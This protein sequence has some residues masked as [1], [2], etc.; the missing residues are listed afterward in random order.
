MDKRLSATIVPAAVA[1]VVG[2]VLLLTGPRGDGSQDARIA[3]V[4]GELD[5]R[6]RETSAGVQARA[7]TLS[8]LPRLGWAVSTD[9]DTV[10]DL[11]ADELA[12]RPLPGESIEI[13][14]IQL[15]GGQALT[16][17]RA[18]PGDTLKLPVA[19][20][21]QRLL[22]DGDR[23]YIAAI[24]AITAQ[25]RADEIRGS[26]VVAQR[27]DLRAVNLRLETVR[28][29]VKI[30]TAEGTIVL[31]SGAVPNSARA[32]TAT[33]GSPAAQ[34]AKVTVLTPASGGSGGGR[35][36]AATIV[37]VL[38]LALSGISWMR[39]RRT[40]YADDEIPRPSAKPT[41]PASLVR[42]PRPTP[43][44]PS[45]S[46]VA[47]PP[48]PRLPSSPASPRVPSSPPFARSPSAPPL[49]ATASPPAS[50]SALP[51]PSPSRSASAGPPPPPP[52]APASH[53]SVAA[54]PTPPSLHTLPFPPSPAAAAPPR[55]TVDRRPTPIDPARVSKGGLPLPSGSRP[56]SDR[57]PTPHVSDSG[58][59]SAV[60]DR[61]ATPLVPLPTLEASGKHALP[62][63]EIT[64]TDAPQAAK[65]L[66][67]PDSTAAP[68]AVIVDELSTTLTS[69]NADLARITDRDRSSL[70]TKGASTTPEY[71]ALF[72]EFV[73]LR[74]TCGE[75]T[76]GL[77]AEKF[78]MVLGQ[79]RAEL[80]SRHAY[81]DVRFWVGFNDGKA[82]IR[83]RGIR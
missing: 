59:A 14:Q 35:P 45:P 75:P 68:V 76:E 48:P 74:R 77:D 52:T 4:V 23:L 7:V 42:D 53:G 43:A 41:E 55:S 81:K 69:L 22:I 36:I 27:L 72:R 16:L 32:A 44:L 28:T 39:G 15:Q 38:G 12:F 57:R 47:N 54:S 46:A 3:A 30:E 25:A 82:V 26:V 10:R 6:I 9:P 29:H 40:A 33:L 64:A 78:V 60:P 56:A 13:A 5:A 24:L 1:L 61:R 37:I 34:S 63:L 17:L 50:A 21:G 11:T 20:T 58:A 79:K 73:E 18:P 2:I 31:G 8:Q 66:P 19:E 70:G 51:S 83:S 80:M 71:R 49:P 65:P 67:E 62:D